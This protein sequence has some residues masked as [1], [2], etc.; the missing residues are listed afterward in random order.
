[1]STP[2]WGRRPNRSSMTSAGQG[3]APPSRRACGGRPRPAGSSPASLARNEL[4]P[5][6]AITTRARSSAPSPVGAHPDH[7]SGGVP[8]QAGGDR[9]GDQP[10]ARRHRLG[11]QPAVEVGPAG[12]HPVVR[13]RPP[14]LP[15]GSRPT[16]TG[17]RSSSWSSGAPPSARP[18]TSL[19][20]VG[21]RP[22][23]APGRRPPR[24]R[25]SS[26]RGTGPA[27]PGPPTG[28]PGPGPGRRPTRP[29]R[30]RPPRRR[31]RVDLGGPPGSAIDRPSGRG[32][33]L[34]RP[35]RRRRSGRAS[36][37]SSAGASVTRPRSAMA[38]IGH[39]GSVLTLTTWRGAPSPPTCWVAPDT[40]KAMYRSGSMATPVVPIWRS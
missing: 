11:R 20:P 37:T 8:Q 34:R 16:P 25:R 5:S 9:R 35:G 24:R 29:G 6:Q 22:R 27:R 30:R 31:S 18:G 23:R 36:S 21:Q 7:P 4:T 19:P 3:R 12:G 2:S 40:P 39:D 32:S 38:V 15:S 10:G 33:T 28:R 14:R 26:T 17:S 13:G 1:M